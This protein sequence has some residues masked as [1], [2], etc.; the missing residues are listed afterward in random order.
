MSSSHGH[1]YDLDNDLPGPNSHVVAYSPALTSALGCNTATYPLGNT[2]QAKSTCFYLVKYITKDAAALTNTLSCLME[3]KK[4]IEQYPSR[5]DDTGSQVRTA[6]H[7]ITKTLNNLSGKMELSAAMAAA[8][9][10]GLPA[11]VS[12]H[13]FWYVFIWPAITATKSTN[14]QQELD[15][16]RDDDNCSSVDIDENFAQKNQESVAD[17]LLQG[18]F[19]DIPVG[20]DEPA[21]G[22]ININKQGCIVVVPQ[23]HNIFIISFVVKV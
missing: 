12:S 14:F 7:L 4:C 13:D 9:L 23:V 5:S 19:G 21:V 6:M 16:N 10:L 17:V 8:S 22:E 20:P 2:A 15:V 1:E 3:A 18:L 11:I